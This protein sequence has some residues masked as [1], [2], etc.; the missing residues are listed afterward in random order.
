MKN[1][2]YVAVFTALGFNVV[3]CDAD[4]VDTLADESEKKKIKYEVPGL[5]LR[6]TDTISGTDS[7]TTNLVEEP[8]PGDDVVPIKPPKP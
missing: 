2:I 6:E 3:S 4:S 7:L 5:I 8:G 1:F